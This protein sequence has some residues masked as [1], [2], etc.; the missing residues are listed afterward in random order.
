MYYMGKNNGVRLVDTNFEAW[1]YG[2]VS[3]SLVACSGYLFNAC[4]GGEGDP[5]QDTLEAVC[6]GLLPKS[7]SELIE[8]THWEKGAW[9]KRYVPGQRYIPI[10]DADILSEFNDRVKEF[11]RCTRLDDKA[12]ALGGEIQYRTICL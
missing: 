6:N 11:S 10:P 3:P 9:A 7:P 12:A 1:D 5:R 8:I 2:P 4:H